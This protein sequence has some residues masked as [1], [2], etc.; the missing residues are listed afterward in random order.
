[1]LI[2]SGGTLVALPGAGFFW[3]DDQVSLD[4]GT[5][6]MSGHVKEYV[7]AKRDYL[8]SRLD[9][10]A[11]G[12][13]GARAGVSYKTAAVMVSGAFTLIF[14]GGC[15]ML[16]DYDWANPA[17]DGGYL[18]DGVLSN[19]SEHKNSIKNA[20]R[21]DLDFIFPWV[22]GAKRR[23]DFLV[24]ITWQH[25][26]FRGKNGF[27]QYPPGSDPKYLDDYG[28]VITY[29]TDQVVPVAGLVYS[30]KFGSRFAALSML[31][32]GIVG[33]AC[34]Y[35]Q[36]H[37]RSLDFIDYY[38]LLPYIEFRQHF[39]FAVTKQFEIEIAAFLICYPRVPG[40]N[41]MKNLKNGETYK[42]AGSGGARSS[43]IGA[44]INFHF[45]FEADAVPD[46]E[47]QAAVAE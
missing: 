2:C 37:L 12:L 6:F 17:P 29:T 43:F 16:K 14:P 4:F 21:L 1:L 47:S 30:R 5:G 20:F 36:H 40:W 9:W 45:T 19:Y 25:H 3:S 8:L 24:G 27:T 42:L 44:E 38:A 28:T 13:F 41:F 39:S 15:G 26:S 23:L 11:H 33:F 34:N 46:A 32:L 10:D 18:Y 22:S 7:F 35:D 31:K